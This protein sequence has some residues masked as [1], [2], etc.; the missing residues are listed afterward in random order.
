MNCFSRSS[1]DCDPPAGAHPASG[2]FHGGG[3]SS[4]ITMRHDE[5]LGR[6]V[7][8]LPR[9]YIGERAELHLAPLPAQLDHGLRSA[10]L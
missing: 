4:R 6:L 8:G 5:M 3:A 9:R 7:A 10:P 2:S 1:G